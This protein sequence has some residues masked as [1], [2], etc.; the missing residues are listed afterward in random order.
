M[1][2]VAVLLVAFSAG[3]TA[4]Q[5]DIGAW[6]YGLAAGGGSVWVAALSAGDVVRLDPETGKVLARIPAGDRM[7]NL[8]SAPGAVWAVGNTSGT[9]ARIDTATGKITAR[10]RVGYQPYDVGRGFGSA[11]VSNAGDGTVSRITGSK[12]VTTIKVGTE[13]NGL[14]A[15]GGFLWVSDHTDGKVIRLDPRT[16]RV[17]GSVTL[18][19][20][21]WIIG[22]RGSL[23]VSQET[24]RIARV[25]VATLKVTGVAKVGHNP[26][27]S[28]IVGGRL[29][30]PCID[31]NEIDDVDTATMSVTRRQHVGHGPIVVLPAYGH[32]WI[33]NTLANAVLKG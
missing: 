12:V 28:A 1:K 33:S 5:V 7:F 8:A 25:S 11:W 13:P 14:T 26:L 22:F 6:S 2:L 27:G 3:G 20:A 21:D 15:Y 10:I 4:A 19:G 16:N 24:N 31:G 18:A 32:T 29:V 23:Y 17:T 30:V 9:V